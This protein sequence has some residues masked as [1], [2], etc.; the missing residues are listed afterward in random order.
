MEFLKSL[1]EKVEKELKKWSDVGVFCEIKSKIDSLPPDKKE[2]ALSHF[3]SLLKSLELYQVEALGHI[4]AIAEILESC[5]M[6][7][8]PLKKI[9]KA[10]FA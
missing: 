4:V 5:G 9:A 3:L 2:K 10:L 8:D 6:N 1:E 7:G